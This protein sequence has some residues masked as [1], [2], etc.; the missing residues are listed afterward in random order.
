MLSAKCLYV[1]GTLC[2]GVIGFKSTRGSRKCALCPLVCFAQKLEQQETRQG[3]TKTVRE[4]RESKGFN[5]RDTKVIVWCD[6][7]LCQ[8]ECLEIF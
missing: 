6:E 2:T 5:K 4:G 8:T 7:G 1:F 3:E